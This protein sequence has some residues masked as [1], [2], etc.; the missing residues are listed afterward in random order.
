MFN[1]Q[2]TGIKFVKPNRFGDFN[3]MCEQDK[4]SNSL[5]IFNDNEEY[6]KTCR[7]GAGN[8]IMRKYNQYSQLKIPKSAGIP[9]GSLVNGG[10]LQLDTHTQKQ[11]DNAFIEIIEL[12][13]D[14][15]YKNIYYSSEP[16]G[17]LGTSIFDVDERVIKYITNKLFSLTTN[18]IQIIKVLSNNYFEDNFDNK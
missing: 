5:F 18:P 3:W 8:A 1:I 9:T 15:N 10:Y 7:S 6:H 4:Y 12:I 17:K 2:V 11:I 16:D 14:Y 13:G